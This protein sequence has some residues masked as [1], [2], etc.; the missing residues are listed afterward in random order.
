MTAPAPSTTEPTTEPTTPPATGDPDTLGDPG[1]AALA[2][3]RKAKRAAEKAAADALARVKELED[4]TKSDA[5]KLQARA[6]A[7]EKE[8]AELRLGA[9]R[10]EVADAKGIPAAMAGRLQGATRDE[11]EADAAEL[12]KLLPK[13]DAA[14]AAP[15]GT[16]PTVATRPV[17]GGQPAALPLN[18]D[19]IVKALE[20]KLGIRSR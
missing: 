17:N 1:K 20:S 18:G 9:L 12:A 15:A 10:R 6:E 11:L 16:K 2:A 19:P 8:L 14:P 5:E 3:E 7:A 4:A 13:P